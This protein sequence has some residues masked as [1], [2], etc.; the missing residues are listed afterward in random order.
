MPNIIPIAY[1]TGSTVPQTTQL[2]NLAIGTGAQDY[3]ASTFL[4][5]TFGGSGFFNTL[6]VFKNGVL[7]FDQPGYAAGSIVCGG[8]SI[9]SNDVIKLVVS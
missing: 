1:N 9:A 8:L 3:G 2:G 4:Q 7:S 6:Q 5:F